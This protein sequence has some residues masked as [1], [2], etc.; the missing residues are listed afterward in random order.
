MGS[1]KHENTK[2]TGTEVMRCLFYFSLLS[3][4]QIVE[5]EVGKSGLK[6]YPRHSLA[7]GAKL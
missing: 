7:L 4:K 1:R 2:F 3:C 5:F 6:F